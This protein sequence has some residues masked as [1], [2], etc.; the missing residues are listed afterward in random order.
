MTKAGALVYLEAKAL[1]G[2]SVEKKGKTA[3]VLCKLSI[4]CIRGGLSTIGSV[5]PVDSAD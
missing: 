3:V 5:L 4:G 1:D 2:D